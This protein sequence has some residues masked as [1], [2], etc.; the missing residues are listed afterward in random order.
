MITIKRISV[1]AAFKVS[2]IFSGLM[3][4]VTL[5]F[6]AAFFGLLSNSVSTF[7]STQ[8]VTTT[9]T[10][11]VDL[12]NTSGALL[13]VFCLCGVVFYTIIGGIFGAI[14]AVAYNFV[15]RTVGGLEL[16]ITGLGEPVYDDPFSTP[17]R[18]RKTIDIPDR[19]F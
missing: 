11:T 7:S 3:S 10:S 5:A 4:I 9:G 6:Y 15:A 16:E 13:V 19:D 18:K 17:T 1:G 12:G 2:A 14:G 8:V